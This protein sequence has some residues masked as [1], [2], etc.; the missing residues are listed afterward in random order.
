MPYGPV[1]RKISRGYEV[2]REKPEY[3]DLAAIA[4]AQGKSLAEVRAM[5]KEY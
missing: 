5:L 4:R 1:R 2:C 3:E